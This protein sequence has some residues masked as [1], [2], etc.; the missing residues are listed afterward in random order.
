MYY[1]S[2]LSAS[3]VK[4]TC[5][6]YK[7]YLTKENEAYTNLILQLNAVTQSCGTAGEIKAAIDERIKLL[8]TEIG[9]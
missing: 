4:Q 2:Y 8:V 7:T 1:N 6:D 5:R 9:Y 3:V